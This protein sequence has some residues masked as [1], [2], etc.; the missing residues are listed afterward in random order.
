MLNFDNSWAIIIGI[1]K[2]QHGIVRLKT[3]VSDAT[4]LANLLK[5]DHQYTV[6]LLREESATLDKLL[7][8]FENSHLKK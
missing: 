5:T 7:D 1:N 2:Y 4:E 8:L 6:E 3:A